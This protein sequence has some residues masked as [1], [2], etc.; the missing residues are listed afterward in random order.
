MPI[1]SV[2]KLLVAAPACS[3]PISLSRPQHRDILNFMDLSPQLKQKY[4]SHVGS[5]VSYPASCEQIASACSNMSE[6]SSDE[7]AWFLKALPH[8][9][10]TTAAEVDKAVGL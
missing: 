7:K 10:Y 6:F 1:S 8:G 2:T 5:D 3:R 9:M 4:T